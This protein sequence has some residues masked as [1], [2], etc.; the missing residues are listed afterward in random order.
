MGIWG[1][2]DK[3]E[4]KKFEE[5]EEKEFEGSEE[6]EIPDEI[7][8]SE[9]IDDNKNVEI[10]EISPYSVLN[11]SLNPSI[12]EC[13]NAYMKL[14]TIPDRRKRAEACLAYDILC[15]TQKYIKNGDTF[16]VK[17]KRLLLLYCCWKFK[18]IKK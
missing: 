5:I 8:K 15:N 1:S 10:N 3:V 18:F 13:R 17:K 12:S 6:K 11:I 2:Y 4:E 7:Y 16:R 9:F 14:A